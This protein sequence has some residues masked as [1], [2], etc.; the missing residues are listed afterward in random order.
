[1][2]VEEAEK[3]LDEDMD[4]VEKDINDM[5]LSLNQNQFDAICSFVYNCGIGNFRSSTLLKRIR[6]FKTDELI[7]DAFLMWVYSGGK[8]YAGLVA[9]R[10]SEADLYCKG[11]LKFYN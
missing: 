10:K 8:R 2:T 4:E 3:L 6:G 7:R 9:R 1:M 5:N 11:E